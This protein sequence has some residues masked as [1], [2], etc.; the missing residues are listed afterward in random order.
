MTEE[1]ATPSTTGR[2]HPCEVTAD[3]LTDHLTEYADYLTLRDRIAAE[4]V[5]AAL[6][7][8]ARGER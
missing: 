2:R 1:Q 8:I 6:Q 7:Q 5:L 3:R 4:R